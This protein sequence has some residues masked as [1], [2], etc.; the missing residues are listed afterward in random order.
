MAYFIIGAFAVAGVFIGLASANIA[1]YFAIRRHLKNTCLNADNTESMARLS[2]LR[3]KSSGGTFL[4]RI[5]SLG[6]LI[7]VAQFE[8]IHGPEFDP[9]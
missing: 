5:T 9:E 2:E 4:S 8:R 1:E 6:N 7:A 3:N